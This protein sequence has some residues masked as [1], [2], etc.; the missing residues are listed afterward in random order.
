VARKQTLAIG[1][2]IIVQPWIGDEKQEREAAPVN[3][4]VVGI[5]KPTGT[6]WDNA[7][8]APLES[9]QKV[10]TQNPLGARSIWGANVL[11][12]YL[13]YL[14][15]DGM[16][17]LEGLV[18]G[19]TVAEVVAVDQEKAQLEE[20]T[21]T[22]RDLGVLMCV[23]ILCLGG[24]TVAAMMATRFDAM[25]VQLAVLRALG[26]ARSEITGWLIWE[27]VL[28]G[29]SA[30]AIG[31]AFDAI[32]LPILRLMLGSALPPLISVPLYASWPVWL[33]A[34]AAT[35]AAVFVPLIRLYHQDVHQALKG[36]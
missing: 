29:A 9:A 22:G 11:N 35:V 24:L 12:Y 23:L 7:L 19:R 26:Y 25:T 33:A 28:L 31:A 3:L 4:N 34:I 10:F 2:T 20:L 8:F 17:Q 27:G 16:P 14:R 21:G 1:Q 30:C 36:T 18:N 5:L 15:P 32:L 13:V 6:A